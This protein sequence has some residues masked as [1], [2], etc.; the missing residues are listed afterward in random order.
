[1]GRAQGDNV[2]VELGRRRSRRGRTRFDYLADPYGAACLALAEQ[3]KTKQ[4]FGALLVRDGQVIG[5]GRNRRSE[6]GEFDLLG[7]DI[8]YATHAEQAA[9]LDALRRGESLEGAELFVL[10][11][12][13]QGPDKGKLSVRATD[14]DH[15]FSCVRCARTFSRHGVAVS[16]PLPSGWH[17]LEP[18]EC[19]DGALAFRAQGRKRVFT[20]AA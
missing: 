4:C 7:G 11:K 15:A 16:I 8:D 6:P 17:R 14:Q 2:P 5:Q 20:A 13:L 18:Q 1:M 19:L 10:G 12:V 3:G 9:I